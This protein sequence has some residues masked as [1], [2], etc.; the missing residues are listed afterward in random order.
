MEFFEGYNLK[1]V[2]F[3]L[4]IKK[5][6]NFNLLQKNH[7]HFFTTNNKNFSNTFLKV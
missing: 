6:N 3:N 7:S 4:D 5:D 1:L 2:I